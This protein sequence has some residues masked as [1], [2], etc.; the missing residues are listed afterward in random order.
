MTALATSTA[1]AAATSRT[2]APAADA[3]REIASFA[4]GALR[5]EL[6]VWPKPG[7]VSPRDAGAHADMDA[8]TFAA[9][10]RALAPS[11][12]AIARAGL[13]GAPF[14]RLRDLGVLAE[15]RMLA[16]TGGVNT[17]R[18][19]LFALGLLAAAAGRLAASGARVDA[20]SLRETVRGTFGPAIRRELPRPTESHGAVVARRHGVGGARAEAAAG[21]PHLFGVALPALE[22]SRRRGASRSAAAVQA[23]LASVATLADTNLLYRGGPAGLAFARAAA[24]AFLRAGG[25]HREGWEVE[26]C[27]LH[28]AFV[29]RRLS[30]G[31][32]A[33][34]LAAALF[35]DGLCVAARASAGAAG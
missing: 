2:R 35:V 26:A 13:T 29:A 31:G 27:A 9:S 7:L 1:T 21:F 30:P 8:A 16:A 34:V 5:E 4:I 25:V 20:A 23:L 19:A 15:A 10:L 6:E 28:A 33:D 12:E 17:H 18:G 22:Q 14:A 11:F 32:S 3:A 24:R